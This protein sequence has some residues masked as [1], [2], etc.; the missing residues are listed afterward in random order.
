MYRFLFFLLLLYFGASVQ[1]LA[2]Q[3]RPVWQ[4]EPDIVV[5]YQKFIAAGGDYD[6]IPERE[7]NKLIYKALASYYGPNLSHENFARNHLLAFNSYRKGDVSEAVHYVHVALRWATKID[8]SYC[9]AASFRLLSDFYNKERRYDSAL[10]Y[11]IRALTIY[12]QLPNLTLAGVMNYQIGNLYF[13]LNDYD[14]ALTYLKAFM[15][16]DRRHNL[17][18]TLRAYNR[19]G[20]IYH[21]LGK[22]DIAAGYFQQA[23]TIAQHNQMQEWFTVSKGNIGKTYIK[24][25][26]YEAAIPLLE[27]SYLSALEY[28]DTA[29]AV[30]ES[31]V[32]AETWLALGNQPKAANMMRQIQTLART[33]RLN[34]EAQLAYK[35]IQYLYAKAKGDFRTAL[36][37][38]EDYWQLND[39]LNN[40][41]IQW[42]LEQVRTLNAASIRQAQIRNEQAQ[43][44]AE[45]NERN[46][47][48]WGSILL[49]VI[50]VPLLI[51]LVRI[52]QKRK[53]INRALKR[54]EDE[55]KL[56]N[57]LLEKQNKKMAEQAANLEQI[58]RERTRELEATI[59]VLN[60]H[61]KDL[62]Q[63]SYIVSHNIRSPVTQIMG[64]VNIINLNQPDDPM[65]AEVLKNLYKAASNLDQVIKDLNIIISTR[66]SLDTLKEKVHLEDLMRQ[67]IQGLESNI[68][69]SRAIVQYDFTLQ[70]VLYTVKGYMHSILH[71]L[72]SN[73]IKYR[74]ENR[75]PH[76]VVSADLLGDF[77]CISVA[78]NGLGIDLENT[79]TY[80]I[81][82]LYQRMHT[83]TEGKGLGLYLVKTQVESLGGTIGVESKLGVGTV[84]RV[85]LPSY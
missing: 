61:N 12:Q 46:I 16:S 69:A 70:P 4:D 49:A 19:I 53:K 30:I 43:R 38:Y 15:Q 60:S 84:F 21:A 79:D 5:G 59:K 22:Y 14:Q 20:R 78:D 32:L 35:H 18:N 65:N 73:A 52:S 1:Q 3:H 13:D 83:H 55:I 33:A 24:Q 17:Q 54:S 29:R 47:L 63:F 51:I 42:Q 66:Q 67:V 34:T 68:A 44:K 77:C 28:R 10:H 6:T 9:K 39:S 27:L 56:K 81:F 75:R 58:V 25:G 41:K 85:M 74:A 82:G 2:G 40:S 8:D 31:S 23:A 80:K 64:L 45:Q 50:V 7:L 37:L 11:K 57:L 76:I 71:N 48:R 72:V 62:E 36:Q 26:K